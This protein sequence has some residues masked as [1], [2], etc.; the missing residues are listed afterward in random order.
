[1]STT[2]VAKFKYEGGKSAE[3]SSA[4][5]NAL[6]EVYVWF[7]NQFCEFTNPY[8][9]AW[10]SEYS[11]PNDGFDDEGAINPD[12][13]YNQYIRDKE[14]EIVDQVLNPLLSKSIPIKR[15]FIGEECDFRMEMCDGAVM[16]MFVEPA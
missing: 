2:Y 5:K 13:Q 15:F 7:Y 8:F 6:E 12:S 1:M 10:N 16:Q 4:Y 11:G 9:E 14:T 3:Y